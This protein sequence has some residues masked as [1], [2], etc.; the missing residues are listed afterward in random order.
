MGGNFLI[1]THRWYQASACLIRLVV[2]DAWLWCILDDIITIKYTTD[3][4]RIDIY[5]IYFTILYIVIIL[6]CIIK[7]TV[8]ASFNRVLSPS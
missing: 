6:Q 5:I 2:N 7:Y 3:G 8:N 1:I 4:G